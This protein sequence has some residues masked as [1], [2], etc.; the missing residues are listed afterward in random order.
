M[1]NDL[2][3]A[4]PESEG[5]SSAGILEF[6]DFVD[7]INVNIYSFLLARNGKILAEGYYKPLDENFRHRLYS[8]SK[9]YVAIGI[10]LLYGEGKLKLTDRLID[11]FPEC[12]REG[13]SEW[14]LNCTID[15]ALKM[16]VPGTG[17]YT[18][19]DDWGLSFFRPQSPVT[20]PAG[21]LYAYD[22]GSSVAL[23]RLIE[24]LSGKPFLEY[25][26]PL[27]DKIGVGKDIWC[28]QTPEGHGWGGSGVI[29]TTRDFAKFGEL[30]LNM[31]NYKG[32][33]LIPKDFMERA[34]SKL[35]SNKIDN[36]GGSYTCSGYGYQIWK[37][38]HGFWLAGMG[39]Q[40]V[41][42]YPEKNMVF[43][44]N[45]DTQTTGA[46][47][48][49]LIL[50]DLVDYFIYDKIGRKR[51]PGKDYER[52]KE[53]LAAL[54]VKPKLG[55]KY[56]EKEALINGKTYVLRENACGWKSFRFDFSEEEG[57]LTYENSRGIK[58][59]RF[60]R[61][62]YKAFSFP[63]THYYDKKVGTPSNREF[64]AHAACGWD[65]GT[66]L[67]K[68]LVIDSNKGNLLMR[69]GFTDDGKEAAAVLVKVAEFFLE[70]YHGQMSGYLKE[71]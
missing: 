26:R 13:L 42:C 46:F 17:N 58:T 63:E 70:D 27:F 56:S 29:C 12:P 9:T 36:R 5:V 45:C 7:R 59:I 55:E 38:R 31:G 44:C 35:V 33:Q 47:N 14:V 10:G 25:M 52:L 69:F 71:D 43:A 66:L 49:Y 4:A 65:A 48:G 15:D 21:T 20:K 3:F 1:I 6:I 57:C 68:V 51:A 30:L 61:E 32:E 23:C 11:Y 8:S 37:S 34:T 16:S 2:I 18:A 24:K 62:K 60:G 19:S 41:F 67:V 64:S 39:G 50:G 40:V 22:T 54:E 53:R 28:V